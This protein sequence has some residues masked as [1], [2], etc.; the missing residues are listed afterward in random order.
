M[1]YKTTKQEQSIKEL[2]DEQQASKAAAG[3][4]GRSLSNKDSIKSVNSKGS[5]MKQESIISAETSHAAN[6]GLGLAKKA[7]SDAS[8]ALV[9][10][11][12]AT[13]DVNRMSAQVRHRRPPTFLVLAPL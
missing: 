12:K 4:D 5:M 10:A 7:L 8:Q 13:E 1:E 2:R 11:Q 9:D 6:I 3:M